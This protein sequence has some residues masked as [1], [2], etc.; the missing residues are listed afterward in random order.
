MRRLKP[1]VSTRSLAAALLTTALVVDARLLTAAQ[2]REAA[3]LAAAKSVTCVFSTMAVGTWNS[4][5]SA[6]EIKPAKLTL[7]F[8]QIETEDGT[9]RV[10]GAF[11]PS[12]IIVKLSEGTLH[13]MQ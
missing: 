6:A 1:A 5:T 8:D 7:G 2:G 13:F 10:I 9:A 12:D 4:G 3:R 11:G